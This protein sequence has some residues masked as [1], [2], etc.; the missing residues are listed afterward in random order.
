MF[1]SAPVGFMYAWHVRRQIRTWATWL[2]L[3]LGAVFGLLV[4]LGFVG[5]LIAMTLHYVSGR[6]VEVAAAI[7]GCQ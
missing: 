6:K 4:L 7:L 2:A 1:L 5:G 3:G